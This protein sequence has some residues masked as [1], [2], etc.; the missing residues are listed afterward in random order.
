MLLTVLLACAGDST[1]KDTAAGTGDTGSVAAPTY[2]AS[3]D[4]VQ[5][6]FAEH[7]DSCHPTTNGI[8][9]RASIDTYVVPGDL[10]ASDLWD[11]VGGTSIS[12]MMPPSGRLPSESVAHVEDW[13]LAGAPTET[14]R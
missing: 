5:A 7:C 11:A 12:T 9:L 1:S 6:M 4:G 8:D 13:I 14:A 2:E 10:E 3:W